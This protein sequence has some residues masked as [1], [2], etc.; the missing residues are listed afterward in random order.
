M[1][2]GRWIADNWFELLNSVGIVGGLLFTAFS[3]RSETK[4]RRIANLL[5]ITQNHREI[6]KEL[7]RNPRLAR[8][9]NPLA[10]AVREPVTVEEELFVNFLVQH[11]NSAYHAMR[12][13]VF[14][15]PDGLRR[16]V[17]RFFSLPI[18]HAVWE[19]VK[20]LQDSTFDAFVE[21]CLNWK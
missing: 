16:D 2:I 8:V 9:M 4:T 18:P 15:K 13:D 5:V 1:E 11:L 17:Y 6:W 12:D 7:L 19:K 14:V 3:L 20:V 10:D 21:S